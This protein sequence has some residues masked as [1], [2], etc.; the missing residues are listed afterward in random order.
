MGNPRLFLCC[1]FTG[2]VFAQQGEISTRDA[3]KT[4]FSTRVDL[5]MVPVVVRDKSGHAIGNLKKE[6]FLIADRGKPQVISRF[7]I[8]KASELLAVKPVTVEASTEEP[9]AAPVAIANRF[10]AFLF[11]DMHVNFGDLARSRDAAGR[12]ID[13]LVETERAAVFTTSGQTMLD[14]TDDRAALRRALLNIRPRIN[15]GLSNCP[16]MTYYEADLI[17]RNDVT[18]IAAATDDTMAC[19]HLDP[20]MRPLG[21]QMAQQAAS[22][23]LSLG[24]QDI[25][26]SIS[27]LQDVVRRMTAAPG[28]RTIVLVSPGFYLTQEFREHETEIIDRAIRANVMINALDARGL[29]VTGA[30]LSRPVIDGSPFSSVTKQRFEHEAALAD[31]DILADLSSGTGGTFFHNNNDFDEGF[32]RIAALP[33]FIYV[34]GFAPQNLKYDGGFHALKVT[35]KEKSPYAL[36][37]RRGYYAPKHLLDPAEQAR[38]EVTE[39]LFSRDE[40]QDIPVQLQTQFFKPAAD[41]AKLAVVAK[42]DLRPLQFKKEEG[43]NKN[44]LTVL[45]GVFDRNGKLVNALEK[46][47]EMRLKE[48]TFE[49][50]LAA[51][52]AIKTNF[53]VTP[54]TYVIR[55]VVRDSEGQLMTARNGAVQIP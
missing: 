15:P 1:A 48:E 5:V 14:F 40:T 10:T 29:Y 8:E 47:I 2:F 26:V 43:R 49:A 7:A 32:K 13:A 44:T 41:E 35:L 25:Q 21:T 34:L 12:R 19:M 33:E 31:S 24:N 39:A 36:E 45:S 4:T 6:D 42:I 55:L 50:R 3:Q 53:D 9:T 18:A 51:G 16:P 38:R 28:Q 11:D 54:G 27:V 23:T 30:D 37:A 46:T 20:S 17:Q 52:L 22:H